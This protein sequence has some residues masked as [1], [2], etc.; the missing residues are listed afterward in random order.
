VNL[1][2]ALS[3]MGRR[4]LVVDLD[5]QANATTWLGVHPTTRG[6]LDVFTGERRLVDIILDKTA[7][8]VHLVPSST[9]L[10]GVQAATANK[11]GAELV[12][13]SALRP[14]QGRYDYVLMDCPPTLGLLAVS[15]LTACNELLVPVSAEVL[16]IVGVAQLLDTLAQVQDRLNPDIAIRGVLVCRADNRTLHSRDVHAQLTEFFRD[17]VFRTVVRECVKLTE[18]P[19]HGKP[20]TTYAPKSNGAVDYRNLAVE[21]D[22]RGATWQP[23]ASA[24]PSV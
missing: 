12:L 15:A 3:E 19:S 5:P 21:V 20:I 9:Y 4:V 23:S 18:A 17:T 16:S 6:V 8:G 13:K 24:Q 10:F 11:A 7:A 22:L 14:I 2:A 1:A